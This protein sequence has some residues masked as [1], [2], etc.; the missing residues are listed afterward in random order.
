MLIARFT[1]KRGVRYFSAIQ[2]RS[3]WLTR[4]EPEASDAIVI[5]Q[6]HIVSKIVGCSIVLDK[7]AML[8]RT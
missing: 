1:R 5:I 6:E 8:P 7:F 3:N 2:Q 4:N